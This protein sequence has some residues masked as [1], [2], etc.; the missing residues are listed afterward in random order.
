VEAGQDVLAFRRDPGFAC[1]VNVGDK[2]AD[3]RVP[4][5]TAV[6]YARD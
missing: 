3:G 5:A 6:W 4:G 1:V 2:P